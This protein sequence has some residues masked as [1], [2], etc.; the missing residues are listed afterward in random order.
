M[1]FDSFENERL[2]KCLSRLMPHVNRDEVALTGGVAIEIILALYEEP[3]KRKKLSDVDFVVMSR[4]SIF[5][6]VSDDFLVSHYH[7]PQPGYSKFLIQLVD[8]ISQLRLDIFPG[9]LGSIKSAPYIHLGNE[10]LLVLDCNDILE[11]KILTLSKSSIEQPVDQKHYRDALRLAK[12]CSK[13]ISPIP[14][15]HFAKEIYSTD[16]STSCLR[17]ELSV[18]TAFPLASKQ[19]IFDILGYV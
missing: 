17:C 10:K 14:P 4:D 18:D 8:P 2:Y 1:N 3:F 5:P 7:V 9:L 12:A 15:S 11:H 13:H 16:L 6:T 19:N